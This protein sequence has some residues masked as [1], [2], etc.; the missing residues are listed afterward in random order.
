MLILD[1]N[2]R[3]KLSYVSIYTTVELLSAFSLVKNLLLIAPGYI[4][5]Y[6]ED[7]GKWCQILLAV[8]KT[9]FSPNLL[10]VT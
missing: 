1:R 8:L 5:H 7:E 10:A 3:V 2:M 6:H 9:V 4:V